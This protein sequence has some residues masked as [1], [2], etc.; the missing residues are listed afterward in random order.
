MCQIEWPSSISSYQWTWM[1]AS[2]GT[3]LHEKAMHSTSTP[4]ASVSPGFLA[5]AF[6]CLRDST[7]AA[8]ERIAWFSAASI[9]SSADLSSMANPA[10]RTSPPSLIKAV[11]AVLSFGA[12][13]GG[14]CG[15]L[16]PQR[17]S[18]TGLVRP[19]FFSMFSRCWYK[20]FRFS[21]AFVASCSS[22]DWK[23]LVT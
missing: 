17:W 7:R 22:S 11:A 20:I 6:S 13:R 4:T 14:L 8:P 1:L 23:L 15:I 16:R 12:L 2:C 18:G 9:G 10:Q 3:Q 21:T 5:S 19:S